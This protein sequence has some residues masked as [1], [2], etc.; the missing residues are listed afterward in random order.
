MAVKRLGLLAVMAALFVMA[1]AA[2]WV[3]S[4]YAPVIAPAPQE[5]EVL[6]DIED[7]RQ[8]SDKPL[9]TALENH[10]VPLAYSEAENRF[11]CTLGLETGDDWPQLHLTAPGAKYTAVMRREKPIFW[12]SYGFLPADTLSAGRRMRSCRV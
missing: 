4:P 2:V 12:K 10:G 8:E 5:I 7:A 11:Y 6:W 9:V 1:A 3:G